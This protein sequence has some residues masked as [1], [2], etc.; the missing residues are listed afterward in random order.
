MTAETVSGATSS[1][2]NATVTAGIVELT[3]A[4]NYSWA[5]AVTISGFT[6]ETDI[7]MGIAIDGA[8]NVWFTNFEAVFNT[9][10][11]QVQS[12]SSFVTEL[13]KASNYSASSAVTITASQAGFSTAIGIAIDGTG[14]VWLANSSIGLVNGQIGT[15]S[16]ASSIVEIPGAAAPT[17]PP[18]L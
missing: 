4:S 9:S 10:A 1:S 16:N 8:G 15:S 2:G 13:T 7:P 18:L 12:T 17:S 11:S 3:R 14:N 6:S 5:Q